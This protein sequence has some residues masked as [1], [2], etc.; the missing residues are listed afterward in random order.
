LKLLFVN[1]YLPY[2]LED[3][4]RI[5]TY[6]LL[7]HLASQHEVTFLTLCIRPEDEAYVAHFREFCRDVQAYERAPVTFGQRMRWPK[8]LR[9][10]W[11]PALA[12]GLART[13][14]EQGPFDAAYL[15]EICCEAY[16][17]GV[18]PGIRP[19]TILGRQK[20]DWHFYR[21]T[22]GRKP[23]REWNERLDL[24]KLGRLER[25]ALRNHR[26]FAVCTEGDAALLRALEPSA[27][28]TV[29]PNGVDVERFRPAPEREVSHPSV[30][31][32][33]SLFYEANV[34]GLAFYFSEVHPELLRRVPDVEVRLVGKDPAPSVVEHARKPGVRLVGSVPD[35][36]P[37]YA[38]TQVFMVPLR[39]GGGSRIKILE[40]LGMG[41]AVVS[42]TT[43]AEGLDLESGRDLVLEDDPIAFA[44]QIADL[45]GHP[46]RRRALGE[47]GRRTV[48]ARYAWSRIGGILERALLDACDGIEPGRRPAA[49]TAPA[50]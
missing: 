45:L 39:I 8:I 26:G 1:P 5:R 32:V 12:G 37:Y 13:L 27:C 22:Y 7:R 6:H 41:R 21:T 24:W 30:L 25:T 34:D 23:R 2:P 29:V 36:E 14:R 49:A 16:L 17:E 40:A 38:E 18:D 33:G 44:R 10:F 35:I 48:E 46:E 31:F 50:R 11:S 42:T 43:G 3:G 4:G 19:P 47:S 15:D 9:H 28:V 20:I